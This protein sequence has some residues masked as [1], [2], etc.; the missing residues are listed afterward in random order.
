M[1]VLSSAPINGMSATSSTSSAV[2]FCSDLLTKLKSPNGAKEL[3]ENSAQGWRAA[4]FDAV[5]A[6]STADETIVAKALADAMGKPNNQFAILLG[7]GEKYKTD[8]PSEPTEYDDGNSFVE[9]RLYEDNKDSKLLVTMGLQLENK[10]GAWLVAK[11]DW[12]DFRDEFY[13]GLSG[14]E[15]LRAF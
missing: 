13:P 15:W 4:I 2:D 10:N 7:K 8:F 9:I 6:P 11:L 14:R 3:L 1:H 12:Q 5:G